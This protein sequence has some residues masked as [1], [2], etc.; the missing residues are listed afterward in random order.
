MGGGTPGGIKPAA[1][2]DVTHHKISVER[3]DA[4]DLD[5]HTLG[6]EGGRG[7]YELE[8]GGL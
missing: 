6:G 7:V 3:I 2:A 4:I 5:E 8:G 1:S